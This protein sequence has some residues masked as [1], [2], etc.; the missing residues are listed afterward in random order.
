MVIQPLI[1]SDEKRKNLRDL[2]RQLRDMVQKHMETPGGL[3]E[4]TAT[5]DRYCRLEKDWRLT[6]PEATCLWVNGLCP[7]WTPVCCEYCARR[8]VW[9]WLPESAGGTA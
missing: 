7:P 5:I 8:G 9:R 2:Q 1:N 4:Y 3:P 6:D